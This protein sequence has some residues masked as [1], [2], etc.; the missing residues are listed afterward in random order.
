MI[1][2]R[3][4]GDIEQ[5]SCS[6]HHTGKESGIRSL[7]D[8]WL[9][10]AAHPAQ[11]SAP[12]FR[13]QPAK[14]SSR[15]SPRQTRKKNCRAWADYLRRPNLKGWQKGSG[16]ISLVL[17]KLLA[18]STHAIAGALETMAK[19]L[20]KSLDDPANTPDLAE[21]LDLDYESL[22]ETAEE[23][24]QQAH[25]EA[26]PQKRERMPLHKKIAELRQFQDRSQ[27]ISVTTPKER[28]Y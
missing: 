28:R 25:E 10:S 13:T 4:F 14:P 21:E 18:S 6:I 17:W 8:G 7:R 5:F 2:D 3:V 16:V 11:T 26:C 20:Q 24:D 23:W 9:R 27:P 19:R 15:S 22:D 1:D 12:M